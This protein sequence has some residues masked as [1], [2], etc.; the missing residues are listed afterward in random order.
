MAAKCLWKRRA[1]LKIRP[2]WKFVNLFVQC[3]IKLSINRPVFLRY[4]DH[5]L[6]SVEGKHHDSQNQNIIFVN[7]A[8]WTPRIF[9]F[10]QPPVNDRVDSSFHRNSWMIKVVSPLESI[11]LFPFKMIP[12]RIFKCLYNVLISVEG[13]E[14]SILRE[15]LDN[16]VQFEIVCCF[17]S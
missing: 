13:I 3:F 15:Y 14:T 7:K 9:V 16:C 6:I 17:G 2:C 11:P 8:F 4:H 12:D 10:G 5:I 1:A